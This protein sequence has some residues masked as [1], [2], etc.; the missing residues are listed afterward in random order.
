[1]VNGTPRLSHRLLSTIPRLEPVREVILRSGQPGSETHIASELL[2]AATGLDQLEAR[3]LS[4]REAVDVLGERVPAYPEAVLTALCPTGSTAESV[5]EVLLRELRVGMQL[6]HD[7]ND[8]LGVLL[9]GRGHKITPNLLERIRHLHNRVRE[10][11]L[12]GKL[13]AV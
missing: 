5:R 9:V 1:M 4:R 3:G 13:A 12:R 6:A 8:I 10:P 7:V 2:R 11:C